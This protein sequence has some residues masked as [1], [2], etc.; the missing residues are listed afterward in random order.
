MNNRKFHPIRTITKL[1]T[2][3]SSRAFEQHLKAQ[4][5]VTAYYTVTSTPRI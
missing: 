2:S 1:F 5:Q 4:A 3:S